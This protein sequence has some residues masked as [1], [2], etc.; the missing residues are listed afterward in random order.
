MI[1]LAEYSG[2]SLRFVL[3][4]RT[5]QPK[6]ELVLILGSDGDEQAF[7]VIVHSLDGE[8]IVG[9]ETG[10]NAVALLCLLL[11]SCVER[12]ITS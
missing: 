10:K 7:I 6:Q 12:T 9:Q 8:A 2:Y 11:R 1:R 3:S 5:R 4:K